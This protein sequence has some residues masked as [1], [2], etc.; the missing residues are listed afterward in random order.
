MKKLSILA[1]AGL[2]TGCGTVVRGTTEDVV[3][4]VQPVDATVTT[5]LNHRC[6]AMPCVVK[7]NRK[8]K[9]T[10]TASREGYVPQSVFV[11]TK[12]S[13]KG[14]AGFAGNIV[15]G[16]VIGMGV[17]VATGA[18]LDHTPN[19]VV[20]RLQPESSAS[21]VEPQ[22]SQKPAKPAPQGKPVS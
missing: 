10:V 1:L 2:L 14:A 7:V 9:F 20:I 16:G 6:T 18:T 17:D 21:P 4:D 12:V 3:I 13:G 15:A 19:P 5:T 22:P 11:D 8:E